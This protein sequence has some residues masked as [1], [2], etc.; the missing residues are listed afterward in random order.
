MEWIN[1]KYQETGDHQY[2]MNQDE[3]PPRYIHGLA[4]QDAFFNCIKIIESRNISKVSLYA[5]EVIDVE[6]AKGG[7]YSIVFG[8]E[9]QT[10]DGVSD[11]LFATGNQHQ[12]DQARLNKAGLEN[13]N[14]PP[15]AVI[16][17][18]YPLQDQFT[19]SRIGNEKILGLRGTGVSSMDV[20]L[21]LTEER[22][23]KF[24]RNSESE[25]LVYHPSGL[26]P[27][28]ILIIG[29]S[30]LFC[31]ARAHNEKT[32]IQSEGLF[33][34][35]ENIKRLRDIYGI[36]N[37][38]PI[39][40]L[41][42]QLDFEK[43]VLP[44][45]ILEMALLYYNCLLG[46]EKSKKLRETAISGF[47]SFMA[48]NNDTAEY[49]S[50]SNRLIAPLHDLFAE[51]LSTYAQDIGPM[52]ESEEN[53]ILTTYILRYFTENPP[54][55]ESNSQKNEET[56]TISRLVRQNQKPI[57]EDLCFNWQYIVN[58]LTFIDISDSKEYHA[59][60]IK[61]IDRDLWEARRGNLKSPVKY[62][63]DT[64]WRDYRD[65]LTSCIDRGGL[66][67]KSH[68]RFILKYLTI[69]NRIADGPS[70]T[71][72]EK[73]RALILASIID[74]E[75]G[76]ES[77]IH[78]DNSLKM[79]RA[80]NKFNQRGEYFE[81]LALAFLER[82]D[83]ECDQGLIYG[84]LL[85][86]GIISVWNNNSTETNESFK[87]GFSFSD[88]LHPIS[89]SG[90]KLEGLTFIGPP[91]EGIRFFHHTLCRSDKLQPTIQNLVVWGNKL[92]KRIEAFRGHY[93][94]NEATSLKNEQKLS[95]SAML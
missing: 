46:E 33:F 50:V 88:E 44:L 17:N 68:E 24:E 1:K 74:L 72:I 20:L 61:I 52:G 2:Q 69:H 81:V 34:N 5:K 22:G 45:M 70:L 84:N 7:R 80:K 31:C 23:G 62:T 41:R 67:P 79:F 15:S 77:D 75:M 16:T 49:G 32:H 76:S 19:Q 36:E 90:Q 14:C 37:H 6:I 42:K 25:T 48:G 57:F 8:E 93:S 43:H 66:T 29:R 39:I 86:K 35:H 9:R 13:M 47:N 11:I 26:E 94:L 91:I 82:F 55:S 10:L 95:E 85:E 30:G 38:L 56:Q 92:E 65:V 63:C 60:I 89:S 58:A 28:K 4:L 83:A 27:K 54:R 78:Y 40:G 73:L 3:W 53:D 51:S 59:A 87:A 21:Y 12:Q 18:V 71:V 64:V